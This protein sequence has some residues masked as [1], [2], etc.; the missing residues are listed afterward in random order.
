MGAI[1][2][3]DN[4]NWFVLV[5]SNNKLNLEVDSISFVKSH[6]LL[7]RNKELI[8]VIHCIE[9]SIEYSIVKAIELAFQV[10]ILCHFDLE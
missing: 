4:Q 10:A 2:D 5:I 7:G 3:L 9:T 1:F 6:Q 8:G